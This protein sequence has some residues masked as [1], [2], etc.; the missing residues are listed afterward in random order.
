MN[1]H[2]VPAFDIQ[3]AIGIDEC[4]CNRMQITWPHIRYSDI[5]H[6]LAQDPTGSSLSAIEHGHS[7]C[8]AQNCLVQTV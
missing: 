7:R 3:A 5:W 2:D 6:A 1:S 4:H 8:F